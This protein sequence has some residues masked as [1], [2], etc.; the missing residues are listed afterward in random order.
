MQS[1]GPYILTESGILASG[2]MNAFIKRKHYNRCK[3]IHILFAAALQ[4]L[5]LR[6]FVRCSE[7]Y[8]TTLESVKNEVLTINT[9]PIQLDNL[10]DELKEILDKYKENTE[11]TSNGSHG[12]TAKYWMGYIE[13]VMASVITQY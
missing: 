3:R 12:C 10:S 1:G 2:S 7:E 5:K 4:L 8:G 13:M 11:S 9:A 6:E